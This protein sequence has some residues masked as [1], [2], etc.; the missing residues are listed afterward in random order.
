[1]TGFS[2]L[3]GPHILIRTCSK[4][5]FNRQI[6]FHIRAKDEHFLCF[7]KQVLRLNASK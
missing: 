7:I 5:Y 1:V 6:T 2:A 3:L 4:L